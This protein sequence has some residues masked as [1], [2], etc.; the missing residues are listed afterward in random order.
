MNKRKNANNMPVNLISKSNL[1]YYKGLISCIN[2]DPKNAEKF[3][4]K[5]HKIGNKK[6]S[7]V[8]VDLLRISKKTRM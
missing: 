1:Y 4:R 5:A 8:L 2:D 6:A 3:L 7:N